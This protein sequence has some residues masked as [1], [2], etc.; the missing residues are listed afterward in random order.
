MHDQA[1][2]HAVQGPV[3]AVSLL[4]EGPDGQTLQI[5][6]ARLPVTAGLD[7]TIVVAV[8]RSDFLHRV[9][10]NL[11]RTI[12]LSLIAALA[13]VGVG[14]F[15]LSVVSRDLHAI[16]QAARQVGDGRFDVALNVERRDEIGDLARSFASMTRRLATDR[17]TGVASREAMHRRIHDRIEQHRRETDSRPFALLFLDVDDFKNVND[18]LGHE[19]GDQVLRA[20]AGR[21]LQVVREGDLV[22]RWAGDEFLILLDDVG[23]EKVARRIGHQLQTAL[24][25]PVP[26][27]A[28]SPMRVSIGLA[29]HPRDG[30]E[31]A[32]LVHAADVDM[33]RSKRQ[34]SGGA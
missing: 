28:G 20:L 33:Y 22:A 21:M 9:T 29:M 4:A 25:E 3:P 23:D 30:G 12:A 18:S 8:P 24:A 10:S 27:A 34:R 5:A 13:V 19:A 15:S 2:D 31:L 1:H 14:W 6:H 16:G 17:L 11:Y 32:A 7:W 26:E